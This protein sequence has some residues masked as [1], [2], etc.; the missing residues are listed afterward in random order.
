MEWDENNNKQLH[1]WSMNGTAC[2]N[3]TE[4]MFCSWSEC[5][6]ADPMFYTQHRCCV[7]IVS[8]MKILKWLAHA[9]ELM[10]SV[11]W[12]RG[13]CYLESFNKTSFT[14][15]KWDKENEHMIQKQTE[16][17]ASMK[18][19]NCQWLKLGLNLCTTQYHRKKI[20]LLIEFKP[21]R[22]Q[23]WWIFKKS[24]LT[25]AHIKMKQN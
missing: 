21:G 24:A 12:S 22:G 7:F 10:S 23:I 15:Y 9:T 8:L 2:V 16:K 3:E 6:T 11:I 19:G 25:R 14:Y 17:C 1:G 4:K 18:K 13:S 20:A 5:W